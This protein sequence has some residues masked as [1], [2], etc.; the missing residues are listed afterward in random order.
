[1]KSDAFRVQKCRYMFTNLLRLSLL[2]SCAVVLTDTSTVL[3]SA[4]LFV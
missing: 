4:V 2:R 3:R 1:M